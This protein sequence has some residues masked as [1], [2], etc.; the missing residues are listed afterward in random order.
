MQVV[1]L[2]NEGTTAVLV[3]PLGRYH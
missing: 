1:T 2:C 3:I